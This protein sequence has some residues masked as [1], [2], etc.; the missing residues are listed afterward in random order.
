[1]VGGDKT[2]DIPNR[3]V[4]IFKNSPRSVTLAIAAV[5]PYHYKSITGPSV[6]SPLPPLLHCSFDDIRGIA[7]FLF[8]FFPKWFKKNLNKLD[9]FMLLQSKRALD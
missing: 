8:Q 4:E 2:K 7:G 6:L 3:G 5:V 1:M 9:N